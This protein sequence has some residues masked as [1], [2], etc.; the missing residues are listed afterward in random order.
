MPCARAHTTCYVLLT[1]YIYMLIYPIVLDENIILY[2]SGPV[3]TTVA[4]VRV[5][6]APSYVGDTRESVIK[7]AFMNATVRQWRAELCA[8]VSV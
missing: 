6:V 5:L 4:G 1:N 3:Y 8:R 7:Q 2:A